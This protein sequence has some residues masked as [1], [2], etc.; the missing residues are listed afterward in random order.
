VDVGALSNTNAPFNAIAATSSQ[1]TFNIQSPS[2]SVFLSRELQWTTGV[3]MRMNVAV[4]TSGL[5][6]PSSTA[7][8]LFGAG[9]PVVVFGKDVA[10][11]PF[12]LQAMCSTISSTIND[13]VSTINTSD[14]LYEILRLTDRRYNKLRK[15]TPS[16]LDKYQL[17]NDAVGAINNPLASYFD[18]TDYD[19]VP[20]GAFWDIV[21]TDE[22]GQ[23]LKSLG[24][25]TGTGSYTVG[26]VVV[27][28]INGVPVLTNNTAGNA[29]LTSYPIFFRFKATELFVLSPYIFNEECGD[30]VGLF[31]VQNIQIVL[32]F[33]QPSRLVRNAT[34]A[35]GANTRTISDVNF[36]GSAPF[37]NPR[38][39]AMFLTP[40]LDIALP[41]KNI[42]PYLEYPRYITNPNLPIQAGQSE[43]LQSQT[44][45][46]PQIP[47]MLIIYAKPQTYANNG[48][49]DFYLPIDQIS[50]NF[51]NFA[52]LLSSHTPE[53]LYAM[54][55]DNGLRMDWGTW[56]GQGRVVN[57]DPSIASSLAN[58]NNVALVGGFLVLKMGK[59]IT[60]QAGQAPSVVGNYTL[61][62]NCRVN[63]RTADTITP[64]LFVIA[65]NSGFFETQQGSSRIVK[66]VLT[67]SEVISAPP[68]PVAARGDLER[69]VGGGFMSKLGTALNTA[70]GLLSD[71]AVRGIV[72]GVARST[73]NPMLQ[74]GADLAEQ[75]GFGV[76]GGAM[77]HSGGAMMHHSGGARTGGRKKLTKAQLAAL[78]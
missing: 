64:S 53:Q 20:N 26:G 40:S 6:I 14:V 37:V 18:A 43:P 30:S 49:A 68:A 69:L 67:E 45:T 13:T 10:L 71:P 65:V 54:S 47:D 3:D 27:Q 42:V 5:T 19:N 9:T 61:Q 25:G 16:M 78:M 23:D 31:G 55:V 22:A 48:V 8:A 76:T 70:K 38:V 77:H 44:I 50:V 59:D 32:N 21:F 56:N 7:G 34:Q 62:F 75:F 46:L 36:R 4:N 39:N 72:K 12:P 73:G 57:N 52:G 24:G 33:Q 15:N 28:F 11:A 41:P 66:G 35:S 51:D 60:L 58:A 29:I 74:R 63:N 2:L 17:Y 1:M